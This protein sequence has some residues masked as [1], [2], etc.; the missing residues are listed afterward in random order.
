M[1]IDL[2]KTYRAIITT[3]KG[4][5]TLELFAKEAPL[6]VNNFVFLSQEGFY[7]NTPFH[8]IIKDFM[9]QGGDPEGTGRGGP[10]YQFN[11]EPVIRE[12][13]RGT[14]A[15]ANAGP[16]TNGSQ[17]FIM[18]RATP[19][20]KNYTIFGKLVDGESTLDNIADTPVTYS[21]DGERSQPEEAVLIHSIEII[22]EES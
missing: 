14:L 10:G 15:M 4:V 22:T 18:T 11:D 21:S 20:P 3:S 6:A 8:R 19:L 12:Y 9:I 13:E 1:Q 7:N 5:M 16:N 2:N 17:F